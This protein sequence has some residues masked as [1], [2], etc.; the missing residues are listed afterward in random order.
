MPPQAHTFLMFDGQAAE[1]MRFYCTTVPGAELRELV[2]WPAEGSAGGAGERVYRGVFQLGG[3]QFM[4][5]DSPMKHEFG[6]TPAISIFLEVSSEAE[7][8]TCVDGLSLGGQFLMPAGD[9]GFSRRFAWFND[10][11]GVSWQVNWV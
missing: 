3:Q 1:A 4:A 7:F 10:R 6:F 9:Y 2:P 11:F 8:T 5:F